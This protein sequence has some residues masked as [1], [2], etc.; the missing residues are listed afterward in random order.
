MPILTFCSA[1]GISMRE[2]TCGLN[3]PSVCSLAA[4]VE[5]MRPGDQWFGLVLCVSFSALTLMV[6]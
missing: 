5:R 1:Y 3:A 6:E 2:P 4:D